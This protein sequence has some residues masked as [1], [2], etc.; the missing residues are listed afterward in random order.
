MRTIFT[1]LSL[2]ILEA[3]VAQNPAAG[4]AKAVSKLQADEQMIHAITG[5]YV[6]DAAT[7]KLVF[8][9]NGNAGL[10]PASSQKVITSTTA[11][12]LLGPGYSYATQL[13]Y[14]GTI[15]GNTLDGNLYLVG[16]GD[17]SLGSW[18]W[19]QTEEAA[20]K[21][22]MLNALSKAGIKAIKGDLVIDA[23]RWESQATPDGWIWQDIGNYYGAGVWAVNWH[24]NQYDLNMAPGKQ[25]GDDVSIISTVPELQASL[26][27]ELK[28][29]KAGSGDNSIIYLAENGNQ[30]VV[31]GTVPAGERSFTVKGSIP[32]APFYV[33][34]MIEQWLEENQIAING[35]VKIVSRN[36]STIKPTIIID[37]IVSPTF[38]SMNNFFLDK[39]IN[40]YGEAFLKTIGF[41]KSGAGSAAAG[42]KVIRN[43]WN[44]HGIDK[45]ALKIMD[46]S[47]L[48][49]ANRVTAKAL[50]EVMLY[51][52]GRDWVPRF[53][54][55]LPTSNGIKMKSGYINGVRSY[56]GYI[57]SASG[58][59][60]AFAFII[61]NF[62]G[63]P[64]AV[65]E[66]MYKLLDILK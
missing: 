35:K 41:K 44:D 14:D 13:G 32:N 33:A 19:K 58:K 20:V 56:T 64:S 24:E 53:Y 51:A 10:A 66:K 30:G 11:F 27:N 46:G 28:T 60:Y 65:R 26:A 29:G 4:L 36:S 38:A 17:P 48:S 59:E 9:H 22:Q 45:A 7:G 61:N 5:L 2:F 37:S 6:A 42:I 3:I 34:K 15:N 1:V 40:L 39:S 49:P 47:G 62:D 18:R 63:S 31:R 23:S 8:E 54:E 55:A 16:S 12:E 43:F 25:A 21:K 52:R 50:T 57:K